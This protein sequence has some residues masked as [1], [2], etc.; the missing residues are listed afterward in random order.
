MQRRELMSQGANVA[1]LC[2]ELRLQ[3]LHPRGPL[4]RSVRRCACA[5]EFGCGLRRSCGVS[6][7]NS[8]PAKRRRRRLAAVG[9]SRHDDPLDAPSR[10]P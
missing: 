10:Q 2:E 9:T 3:H 4:R 7:H 6:I 5:C 1:R 8:T